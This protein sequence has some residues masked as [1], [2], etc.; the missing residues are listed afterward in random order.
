MQISTSYEIAGCRV[1]ETCGIA[2]GTV[3]R[4]RNIFRDIRAFMRLFIGGEVVEY[5]ALIAQSRE[6]AMDRMLAEARSLGGNAVIGFRFATCEVS[7]AAAE[8]CRL[9][10]RGA[11]RA[12]LES[13]ASFRLGP[14]DSRASDRFPPDREPLFRSLLLN[15]GPGW[16]LIRERPWATV[17]KATV[18]KARA[19]WPNSR[20]LGARRKFAL[21]PQRPHLSP[22]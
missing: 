22:I 4:S 1:V 9:W 15:P 19:P 10:N 6:Q 21:A 5:T 16:S 14:A 7:R 20:G 18:P 3:V 8:V 12:R 2:R 17:P 13:K 11:H